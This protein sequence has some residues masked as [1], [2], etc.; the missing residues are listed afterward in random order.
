MSTKH[1]SKGSKNP[2][3]FK[4]KLRLYSNRFCPY[5]QRVHLV[6]DA[7]KLQ[8]ETVYINLVSKP[9]W[10]TKI[11][12]MG[13]VPALELEN[14]DVIYE[15]LIIANYLDEK[16]HQ[17]ALHP[18]DPLQKAKDSLLIDRFNKIVTSMNK[19]LL[20]T[21]RTLDDQENNIREGLDIFEYELGRRGNFFGGHKPGMLDYV[22]WPWVER[23]ELLKLFN[24]RLS[25]RKDKY[26]KLMEWKNAMIEDNS[27][28]KTYLDTNMHIK[29]LQSLRAGMPECDLILSQL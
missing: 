16:Y 21:G 13:K 23:A 20:S 18:K 3:A 14:G 7:K 29:F 19:V 4:G 6:L 12:P 8:Y 17:N 2:A 27:V 28:K 22:I 11:S 15:S 5:A 9:E 1:L 25:L 24:T 10:Y 26:K